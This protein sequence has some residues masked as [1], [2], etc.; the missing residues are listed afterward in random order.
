M[1]GHWME[2]FTEPD[3]FDWI[4]CYELCIISLV[5]GLFSRLEKPGLQIMEFLI[6]DLG[7]LNEEDSNV[8]LCVMINEGKLG[9]MKFTISFTDIKK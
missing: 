1:F 2:Y 5:T 8:Y 6:L 7:N 3:W 4:N 9:L